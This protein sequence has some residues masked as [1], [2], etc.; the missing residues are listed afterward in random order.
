MNHRGQA[1]LKRRRIKKGKT[2]AMIPHV[3]TPRPN[4]VNSEYIQ[5]MIPANASRVLA[6]ASGGSRFNIGRAELVRVTLEV[7]VNINIVIVAIS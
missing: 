6:E 5:M 7:I 2:F 1:I 3:A 4:C